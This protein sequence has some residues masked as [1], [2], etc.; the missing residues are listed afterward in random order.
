M[1]PIIAKARPKV[2]DA[3][4][5][6]AT[7]CLIM[8]I[9][10]FPLMLMERKRIKQLFISNPSFLQEK[11]NLL[12]GWKKYKLFLIYVGINFAITQFLFFVAYENAGAINGALAQQTQFIYALLFGYL[13]YHEKIS[14]TQLLFSCILFIAL[15]FTVTQGSFNLIEINIGVFVMCIVCALW[16]FAHTLSKPLLENGEISAVQLAFIRNLISGSILISTYFIFYPIEN[17]KL[18]LSP[19]NMFFFIAMGVI[20]AID[21]LFWYKSLSYIEVSKASV[22]VS[23]MPIL[24]AVFAFFILGEIFTIFHLIGTVVIIISIMMIVKEKKRSQ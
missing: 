22:I 24:T 17:I 21:L 10:Y 6:A 7:T 1:Q 18:F 8:A 2:L 16:L 5:F 19:I 12:N 13:I 15:I 20:Y 23:P 3:Y 9:I 11:P 4:I 14:K